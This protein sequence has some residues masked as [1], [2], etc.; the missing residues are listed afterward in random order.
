MGDHIMLLKV[1]NQWAETDFSQQFCLEN[2]I[3]YRSMKRARDIRDQ[4]AGLCERA[5]IEL[6]SSGEDTV[7]V[8]KAF[9][10]GFFYHTSR[11]AKT[12]Y[13]TFRHQ[14]PVS[15]HPQSCLFEESNDAPPRWVIY[16]EL[17]FTTKEYMRNCITIEP[18]WLVEVAPHYYKPGDIQ[19]DLK[20]APKASNKA[21]ERIINQQDRLLHLCSTI[22]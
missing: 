6:L 4:M 21:K 12:G 8:R 7:P 19:E 1:Y 18:K 22:D 17:V 13:K 5:E 14:Q 3:Q 9:T 10:A 20:K 2:F 11:F 16:H 15:I